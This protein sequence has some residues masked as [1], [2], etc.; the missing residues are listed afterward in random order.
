M[1][2]QVLLS[3]A[4]FRKRGDTY[5]SISLPHTWNNLDGQDGGHDYW[6]GV[7]E[8]RFDL[9]D[10]TPGCCQ[11]I[12]VEGANHI[13]EVRCNGLKAG[14][15][16]GGFSSFTFELTQFMKPH[17]NSLDIAVDNGPSDV[18]P[19][20]ADFTFFGGLYRRVFFVET[21]QAHF[22]LS[23]HGSQGVL[24]TPFSSGH[25]RIEAHTVGADGY[26]VKA[27]ILDS[28]GR[29][30][31]QDET[32][33]VSKTILNLSVETPRLWL[34]RQD[35]YLYRVIITLEKLAKAVDRVELQL[36]YRSYH[37]DPDQGFFLNGRP[38]PLRG[39]CRHQDRQDKGWAISFEDQ[40]EDLDHILAIGA[41]A[42]RLAHYQH[43]QYFYDLCDAMGLV[44][45]A[46]IPF[47]SMHE[48][49]QAAR[50]NII[51]QATELILQCKQH[52][53]ICF[54][55]I[56]N[57]VTLGGETE[58]LYQDL[59]N[60]QSHVK[61][62]DPLRLTTMANLGAVDKASPHNFISDVVAYNH[63]FGWY[64][65]ETGDIADW[66]DSFHKT[67]PDRPLAL[68]EYGADAL[69][70]W[71]SANPCNH[72]YTEEYQALLH[73]RMLSIFETRRYL[74]G[75]FVWNL[76]DFASDARSEG[77]SRGRNNKGLVTYD[78]KIRKDAF[79]IYKA[80]WN[81]EPMVHV[82]G[83]R[84]IDRAPGE[85]DVKIYT[86]GETITLLVNGNPV[87]IKKAEHHVAVFTD[88]PLALGDNTVTARTETGLE[89]TILLRGVAQSNPEYVVPAEAGL[90]GNWFDDKTGEPVSLCFPDG[91]FSIRDKL[92]D[93]MDNLEASPIA[94]ELL[95]ALSDQDGDPNTSKMLE[96][97]MTLVKGQ[98]L[99]TL[100]QR[101]GK[102]VPP[103]LI[104]KANQRLNQIKKLAD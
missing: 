72:D 8:Y 13:A 23:I 84:F 9:P 89:D 52:P 47:I 66:L 50:D 82:C 91:Y 48:T 61:K 49:K 12:Q 2:K 36:G 19:Q 83:R 51:S 99:E 43:D 92:G 45:W 80:Y 30:V 87:E 40:E 68:S 59:I 1:R 75:T 29:L 101:A 37:V 16:A 57:E 21:D 69:V 17:D 88:L 20:M 10:P 32:L 79:Y 104:I 33:A 3:H 53:S 63:Y 42:V 64:T 85:R 98:T 14:R 15:H 97:M 86:N 81:P 35:P 96:Q 46:E 22:D 26:S 71:H 62:L 44:V 78:R 67:N 39:V 54:W 102:I 58:L 93:L 56:S 5:S 28:D 103:D 95:Q 24:V 31:V 11:F 25:T 90:A 38:Y 74:W 70:L 100:I 60:L 4:F 34:G 76:F 65:G 73:E 55:G 7:G 94:I 41:N 6:R 77:A 18:Y 27:R